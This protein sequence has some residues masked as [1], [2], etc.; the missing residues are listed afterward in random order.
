[1]KTRT[2]L[3]VTSILASALA[4]SASPEPPLLRREFTRL[5]MGVRTRIVLFTA[6]EAQAES[7]ARATF[8]RIAAL[9]D[10]MSD[11][12]PD[13]EIARLSAHAGGEAVPIS[14]DLARVLAR[15]LEVARASDGAFDPTIGPLVGAWR[16]ARRTGRLPEP[17][18]LSEAKARVGWEG[19]VLD[20]KARTVR[21]ARAGMR[22]DLGGI[23]KGFAASESVAALR[24]VGVTRCLVAL[25]GDVA[26]GDSPPGESGWRV[27]VRTGIAGSNVGRWRDGDRGAPDDLFETYGS[28]LLANQSVSTS[29]D[30][31]QA[32]EIGGARYSHLVDPRSGVGI[33]RRIAACVVANDGALADALSTALGVLGPAEAAAIV[34]KF[35]GVGALVEE[36][37]GD[38]VD[39]YRND[40]FSSALEHAAR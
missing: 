32:I 26:V 36:R 8:D 1:M 9:E 27:V 29:G 24:K 40:E 38:R 7:A 31:E 16:E 34:G 20:A 12:R 10:V 6:T 14:D 3:V 28:L 30:A 22:L 15:A 11:Y 5:L 23:G 39:R 33:T 17:R 19:V 21:L 37:V 2:R 4:A 25:A 18:L 35:G 13:S